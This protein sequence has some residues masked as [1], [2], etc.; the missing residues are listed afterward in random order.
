MS[1]GRMRDVI[2]QCCS[3]VEDDLPPAGCAPETKYVASRE[4]G[5]FPAT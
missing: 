2:L 3:T 4:D 5:E 1:D